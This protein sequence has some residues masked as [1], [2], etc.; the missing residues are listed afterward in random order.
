MFFSMTLFW[1]CTVVNSVMIIRLEIWWPELSNLLILRRLFLYCC[2]TVAKSQVDP[3][4]YLL[5][6]VLFSLVL[7]IR[8]WRYEIRKVMTIVALSPIVVS[9]RIL[10]KF[11]HALAIYTA[12]L[13]F[14]V[15]FRIK[16][17]TSLVYWFVYFYTIEV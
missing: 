3:V 5:R 13:S 7:N 15:C 6:S 1:W 4:F 11:F 2:T 9:R 17:I 12:F 14:P 8:N 16:I 10:M